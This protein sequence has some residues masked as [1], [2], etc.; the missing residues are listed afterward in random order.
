SQQA[1]EKLGCRIL[2]DSQVNKGTTVTIVFPKE[3]PA[4]E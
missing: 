1:A 2:I 4:F 3:I